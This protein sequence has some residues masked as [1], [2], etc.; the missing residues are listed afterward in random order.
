M[1]SGFF[2]SKGREMEYRG[3]WTI[4]GLPVNDT[5]SAAIISTQFRSKSPKSTPPA[6]INKLSSVILKFDASKTWNTTV[7]PASGLTCWRLEGGR[8]LQNHP[9]KNYI[10]TKKHT[11]LSVLSLSSRVLPES[12]SLE[13]LTL[14]S[15]GPKFN[16]STLYSTYIVPSSTPWPGCQNS[17]LVSL[18]QLGFLIVYVYLFTVSPSSTLELKQLTINNR[19]YWFYFTYQIMERTSRTRTDNIF[20]LIRLFVCSFG[21][22][23]VFSTYVEPCCFELLFSFPSFFM[24]FWLPN[25]S[26]FAVS[27]FLYQVPPSSLLPWE[28]ENM[29]L[30][31]PHLDSII[32]T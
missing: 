17:Q 31:A 25:V 2:G 4:K 27:L 19:S 22:L 24:P 8:V 21:R 3:V 13:V 18:N 16:S 32:K 26:S 1:N 14:K 23:F 11:F 9:S 12:E 15:G 29:S 10:N 7:T 30:K 20:F 28:Q 5:Y 6:R